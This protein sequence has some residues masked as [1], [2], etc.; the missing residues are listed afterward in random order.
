MGLYSRSRGWVSR[1]KRPVDVGPDPYDPG[2][3]QF[4]ERNR[5]TSTTLTGGLVRI[6]VGAPVPRLPGETQ[7]VRLVN[8]GI[9]PSARPATPAPAE[10]ATTA[11]P[12]SPPREPREQRAITRDP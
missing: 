5:E 3:S 11:L 10:A 4:R 8:K 9:A 6:D 12:A 7:A 1:D 2:S